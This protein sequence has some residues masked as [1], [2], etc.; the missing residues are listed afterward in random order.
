[1]IRLVTLMW[2]KKR[3]Q[4]T[5]G[6]TI[7]STVFLLFHICL[8]AFVA[9]L[10]VFYIFFWFFLPFISGLIQQLVQCFCLK[11]FCLQNT[12][13][14]SD[15]ICSV[16]TLDT[17]LER[18]GGKKSQPVTLTL[19]YFHAALKQGIEQVELLINQQ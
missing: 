5:V 16:R 8:L 11:D 12:K 2:Q 17:W 15:N 18:L 3:Y 14:I 7:F 9:T 13:Q 10:L 4:I 1:M 19:K 6:T